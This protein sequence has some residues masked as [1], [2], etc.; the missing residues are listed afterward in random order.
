MLRSRLL[1]AT[2]AIVLVFALGYGL[3]RLFAL[4]WERGDVYPA[5][6]TLRA[7]PLGSRVFLESLEAL[8]GFEVQRNY[9]PLQQ[10]RP[11]EPVTLVY[12]GLARGSQWGSEELRHFET[13]ITHG[14][15]A[16]FAFAPADI[17]PE[18]RHRK[19]ANVKVPETSPEQKEKPAD[20]SR[21]SDDEKS[22][23]KSRAPRPS[24][25]S[26]SEVARRWGF[27]FD[28]AT[29]K[30][31]GSFH[32]RAKLDESGPALEP[33]V[34]WHSALRFV[35][36]QGPWRVLYRA[37]GEPV[38]IERNWGDGT[39]VL[40]ADSFF[41]AT[42]LFSMSETRLCWRGSSGRHGP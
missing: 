1:T 27:R 9:R 39:I 33:E 17:E 35:D 25:I 18:A 4:R 34:S 23:E 16:V 10:L 19:D 21:D 26:F 6:S 11:T 20:Q 3:L 36:L 14:S 37:A 5:Y 13:L 38:V 12:A 2:V 8:P 29:G 31:A 42:K 28:V 41:R 32:G 7:D 30:R 22:D 40:A 24:L 15:R